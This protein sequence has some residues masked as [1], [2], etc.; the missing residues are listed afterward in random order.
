MDAARQLQFQVD[1]LIGR[2]Q[3]LVDVVYLGRPGAER[4]VAFLDTQ[5]RLHLGAQFQ[6]KTSANPGT[7]QEFVVGANFPGGSVDAFYMQKNDAISA[8]ALSAAQLTSIQGVCNGTPL[9]CTAP[10]GA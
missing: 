1:L 3:P 8:G 2:L 4:V 7:T 5:Q 6:T 10:S 9:V